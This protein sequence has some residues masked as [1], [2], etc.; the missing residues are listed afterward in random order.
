MVFT[1]STILMDKCW[2][3]SSE[4]DF[5]RNNGKEEKFNF[6]IILILKIKKWEKTKN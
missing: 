2:F 5:K 1:D 3:F 4:S 6:F